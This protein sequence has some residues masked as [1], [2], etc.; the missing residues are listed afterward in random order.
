[1]IVTTLAV[2][3][4]MLSGSVTPTVHLIQDLSLPVLQK[5]RNCTWMPARVFGDLRAIVDRKGEMGETVP[6]KDELERALASMRAGFLSGS[7]QIAAGVGSLEE[8]L[9]EAPSDE[10]EKVGA[11]VAK[12]VATHERLVAQIERLPAPSWDRFKRMVGILKAQQAILDELGLL[13]KEHVL[14]RQ[15]QDL[16][17]TA[18]NAET[19]PPP[20]HPPAPPRRRS[21]DDDAEPVE[22]ERKGSGFK[23]LAAMVVAA[24]ILSLIPRETKLQDVAAKL[25]AL[26]TGG[27]AAPKGVAGAGAEPTNTP[28]RVPREPDD[29]DG[30][31]KTAA[32]P[33]AATAKRAGAADETGRVAAVQP[34]GKRNAAPPAA[35]KG[36]P[37]TDAPPERFVP[38]L[39]THKDHAT[40]EKTLADL[41][42]Q[43]PKLLMDRKGEI[44]PVDLGKKGVWHR[45]VFLP[46]G[47][48]PEATKLCDQLMAEGYDRCWVNAYEGLR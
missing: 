35:E 12:I 3:S 45:L 8:H 27:E 10:R 48:R 2:C 20:V 42:Q 9:A 47:P 4:A 29:T 34:G 14:P 36:K 46:A 21:T 5:A 31:D 23:G 18:A 16:S 30:A 7:S 41:Q 28:P 24:L 25:A 19:P 1:M 32:P 40:V 6:V 26:V 37:P 15:L 17:E 44:L 11:A 43:Y 13:V 38:V 33:P 39:F 22:R